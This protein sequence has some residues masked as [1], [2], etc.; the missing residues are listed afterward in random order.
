MSKVPIYIITGFLGSGKT[1]LLRHI[2]SSH[3]QDAKIAII[4]NDFSDEMGIEAP[5]MQDKDGNLFKEF[6]ELPNGCVCCTVKDELLKAIEH[7]LSMKRFEKILL[8]TTGIADPEPIIEKFWLDCEL[9]SSV[10][11]LGVITV[12]DA[13]N[14]KNYLDLEM[15]NNKIR[16][17]S[18][19]NFVENDNHQEVSGLNHNSSSLKLLSPEIIKQIML[20]NKIVLNKTDLLI[21]N[22]LQESLDNSQE[23]AEI[24]NIVRA[25]N[26]IAN[27]VTSIRSKVEMEWLFDLDA[28]NVHKITY[29]I[30]RAFSNSLIS[31]HSNSS[32]LPNISSCT[33]SFNA[34]TIFDLKSL[35]RAIGKVA[36]EEEEISDSDENKEHIEP[37]QEFLKYNL[38]NSKYGKLIRFKGIFKTS[39]LINSNQSND[40]TSVYALQGVGQI[41]EILPINIDGHLENSKFFFLG[42]K[43]NNDS[44]KEILKSCIIQ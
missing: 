31:S 37:N 18:N 5:T 11:L 8:E 4:Q 10:E 29:E 38:I 43:L 33:I 15:I 23:V 14:F 17:N 42:I 16:S 25:I 28:F 26:P 39:N 7:L 20:A 13:F 24:Q 1:T 36:W 35:E 30:D 41:F 32:L 44:L 2:I 21:E 40:S 27:L 3:D 9:E 6:F 12:I 34:N 22:K 19:D